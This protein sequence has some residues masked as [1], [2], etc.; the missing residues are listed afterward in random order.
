MAQPKDGKV[1]SE[2]AMAAGHAIP[3]AE[4]V[5]GS[6]L[7]ESAFECQIDAF[8]AQLADEPHQN[9]QLAPDKQRA[10]ICNQ[11]KGRREGGK[12]QRHGQWVI[13]M[14]CKQAGWR[15]D[16]HQRV[17]GIPI[18]G[19]HCNARRR[20]RT[21]D[22][23]QR[24]RCVLARLEGAMGVRP[25][26]PRQ[27]HVV[28]PAH[29]PRLGYRAEHDTRVRRGAKP[30][31]EI[32][33]AMAPDGGDDETAAACLSSGT[34]P[35]TRPLR[36]LRSHRRRSNVTCPRPPIAFSPFSLTPPHTLC[37][38]PSISTTTTLDYDRTVHSCPSH[39]V[40]CDACKMQLTAFAH[41]VS[42]RQTPP[43]CVCM[44]GWR[45]QSY[46]S[47]GE[48]I[49]P[50]P[51]SDTRTLLVHAI[52]SSNERPDPISASFVVYT[53]PTKTRRPDQEERLQ[54]PQRGN[55]VGK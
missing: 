11:Q 28:Q 3:S 17:L 34:A 51:A 55:D 5:G 48:L 8:A 31:A 7:F 42:T 15:R 24:Q 44:Q 37:T 33:F 39:S 54:S 4:K 50:L 25:L 27:T 52:H 22:M 53:Q 13:R 20:P 26:A 2:L 47:V 43:A 19:S 16:G 1:A 40:H 9:G 29:V 49:R 45:V 46:C 35:N 6:T 18:M 10:H 12:R 32:A 14:V 41:C 21:L 38:D 30:S 36:S 23:C